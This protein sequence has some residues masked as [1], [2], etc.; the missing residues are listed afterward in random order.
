MTSV[1]NTSI[2]TNS[3]SCPKLSSI[4]FRIICVALIQGLVVFGMNLGAWSKLL[5]VKQ[6]SVH[7]VNGY[8][9]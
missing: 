7:S 5:N 3:S 1:H 2:K 9:L 6:I 4:V 8:D